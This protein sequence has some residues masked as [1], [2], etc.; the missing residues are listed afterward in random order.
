MK[1]EADKNH[2]LKLY[3]VRDDVILNIGKEVHK[4]RGQYFTEE[5]NKIDTINPNVDIQLPVILFDTF[6]SQEGIEDFYIDPEKNQSSLPT[7]RYFEY[8]VPFVRLLMEMGPKSGEPYWQRATL[9]YSEKHGYER[10]LSFVRSLWRNR[11]INSYRNCSELIGFCKLGMARESGREEDLNFWLDQAFD[12]RTSITNARDSACNLTEWLEALFILVPEVAAT[13][14]LLPSNEES[15]KY[16]RFF[17]E[18][19]ADMLTTRAMIS[20][21][22]QRNES[23]PMSRQYLP[24]SYRSLKNPDLLD[25]ALQDIRKTLMHNYRGRTILPKYWYD[26]AV[27]N[28]TTSLENLPSELDDYSVRSFASVGYFTNFSM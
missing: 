27:E 18:A 5:L 3:D 23:H 19:R 14:D 20:F 15:N 11:W 21:F 17:E 28:L 22:L 2:L 7:W 4:A 8:W 26:I 25:E 6:R 24:L 13:R 12:L 1:M 9:S 10:A 16:R